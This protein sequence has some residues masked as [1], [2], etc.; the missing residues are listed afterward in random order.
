MLTYIC[1]A[2][3]AVIP[4]TDLNLSRREVADV[5]YRGLRSA[6]LEWV[7]YPLYCWS[8]GH[9]HDLVLVMFPCPKCVL[10]QLRQL[11][12]YE[13]VAKCIADT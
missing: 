7:L 11:Q 13:A 4:S 6:G 1:A 3:T 10:S 9:Q 12:G 2:I 5:L 8:R